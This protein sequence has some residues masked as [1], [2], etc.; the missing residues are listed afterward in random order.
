MKREESD[1]RLL[2]GFSYRLGE[3]ITSFSL[4]KSN[5]L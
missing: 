3:D 4:D 2:V 5:R 1:E